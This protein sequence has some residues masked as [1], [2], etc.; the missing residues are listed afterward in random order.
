MD[1]RS[2]EISMLIR[3]TLEQTILVD[4]LPRTQIDVFV[5]V[6]QADGGTRSAC[7]NAAMLALGDA[8]IPCRR[9][10]SSLGLLLPRV[11]CQPRLTAS[12]L[13]PS[14]DLVASCA[15][16]YLDGTPLLDLNYDEDAG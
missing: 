2:T 5:Q 6:I 16:G 13:G 7:I 3:S 11:H 12:P 10:G 1:R 15:A 8:G 4:L 14:R 9:A